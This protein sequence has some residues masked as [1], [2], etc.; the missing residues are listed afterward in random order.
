M[1]NAALLALGII[2]S[3]GSPVSAGPV[4]RDERPRD[5]YLA[6]AWPEQTSVPA[7]VGGD[8]PLVRFGP[9]GPGGPPVS[10]QVNVG[11]NGLNT[12]GDAGNEPSLAVDPVDPR[13][14]AAGWRQFDNVASNFR[15]AGRAFSTDGGRTWTRGATLDPGVFRSDPVLRADTAGRFYYLS[16]KVTNVFQ[17]EIFRSL[18]G[19]ATFPTIFEAI[20][21]DK[22][23]LAID[24]NRGAPSY[25][26]LHQIWSNSYSRSRDH[27]ATWETP[28]GG[29]PVF[30][31][32]AVGPDSVLYAA[33]SANN[34][35]V[36]PIVFAKSLN[37]G[38]PGAAPS[39]TPQTP[40]P[41]DGEQ[42]FG[43]GFSSPNPDGLIG[44]ISVDVD[45]TSGPRRGW[46]YVLGSVGPR[47]IGAVTDPADVM[48][49]RSRDG[50]TTWE[51]LTRVNDSPPTVNDWQWFGALAVAP[52][53][54]LDAV[55]L[56][57]RASQ[58]PNLSRAYYSSSSDGGTTW[59]ANTLISPE[60]NSHI[61]FPNQ[62]KIGDYL[63][64][65][66][67]ERGTDV[68]YAAT[69]NGEED[70]WFVRVGPRICPADVNRSGVVNVQDIFDFL[71]LW[72]A[73]DP[74][75]EFNRDFALNVQ[76]IFDFLAAWFGPC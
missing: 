62:N 47:T 67:D 58:L 75:A 6:P 18:N 10:V 53:G 2:A 1:M 42:L 68:L 28:V 51:G 3:A 13:R 76:D 73:Q 54:R 50:G 52:N 4:D 37:A 63:D 43:Q 38:N 30:C 35:S 55:W 66:S 8:G 40:V 49:V 21:G 48:F 22:A 56:D 72:F 74:R 19:G 9:R 11:T 33:G 16:L 65:H 23:W 64:I 17:C 7:W 27:G 5:A 31:T 12:L 59:T 46:V 15:Q 20:G 70:V 26:F 44:Q 34:S 25:G 71:S 45:R 57:T 41:L 39:F 61:G 69:F 24:E 29:N 36:G 60:F 14:M 32:T